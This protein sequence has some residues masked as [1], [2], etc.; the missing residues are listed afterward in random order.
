[1][2]FFWHKLE[3]DKYISARHLHIHRVIRLQ[4]HHIQAHLQPRGIQVQVQMDI[5]RLQ[6]VVIQRHMVVQ[7]PVHLIQAEVLVDLQPVT[8]RHI[9]LA[10]TPLVLLV[11]IWVVEVV[12]HSGTIAQDTKLIL[13]TGELNKTF[14][15]NL[16]LKDFLPV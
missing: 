15:N 5:H 8:D 2:K 3:F 11:V 1:M 16:L 14:R 13:N 12:Q 6:Q 10:V 7:H 9:L 4:H